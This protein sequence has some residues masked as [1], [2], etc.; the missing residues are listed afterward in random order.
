MQEQFIR[1]L[2]I[3]EMYEINGYNKSG[4]CIMSMSVMEDITEALELRN[5]LKLRF[6]DY[7]FAVYKIC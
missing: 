5:I 1:N 2:K 7:I 3:K 6:A 4:Q